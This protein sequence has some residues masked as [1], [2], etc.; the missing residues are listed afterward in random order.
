MSDIEDLRLAAGGWAGKAAAYTHKEDDFYALNDKLGAAHQFV[1]EGVS[2]YRNERFSTAK[3]KFEFAKQA[4]ESI[5]DADAWDRVDGS[6]WDCIYNGGDG[7]GYESGYYK[8]LDVQNAN[9]LIALDMLINQAENAAE[10][11]AS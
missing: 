4:L 8:R 7:S 2:N 6:Y 5:Q 1:E 9:A 11:Q 3:Q 10:T